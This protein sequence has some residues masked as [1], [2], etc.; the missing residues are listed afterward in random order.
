VLG[1][2]EVGMK[3]KNAKGI[4]YKLPRSYLPFQEEMYVHLISGNG[5]M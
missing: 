2:N 1:R 3:V 5:R 4:E